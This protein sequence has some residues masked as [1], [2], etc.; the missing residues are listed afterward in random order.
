MTTN[1]TDLADLIHDVVTD[2]L[3]GA[4]VTLVEVTTAQG[5]EEEPEEA[6]APTPEFMVSVNG[7]GVTE[8]VADADELRDVIQATAE[9]NPNAEI[10]IY[11]HV[12]I[13]DLNLF[14]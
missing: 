9:V 3:R 14:V 10:E 5:P 4:G 8:P 6:P 11:A 1:P 12:D 13:S 2:I 7:T